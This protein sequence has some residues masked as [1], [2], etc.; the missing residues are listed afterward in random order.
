MP[1]LDYYARLDDLQQALGQLNS[2][3]LK[4]ALK[5]LNLA[6]LQKILRL[7]K[8]EDMHKALSQLNNLVAPHKPLSEWTLEDLQ[9]V[10]QQL[11]PEDLRI[12]LQQLPP[13]D[14]CKALTELNLEY[15]HKARRR[16]DPEDT[17]KAL[18]ELNLEHLL[19]VLKQL[20]LEDLKKAL[21]ELNLEDLKK[22][23]NE[24]NLEDLKKALS[25]MNLEDLEKVFMP[26]ND[27]GLIAGFVDD[28]TVRGCRGN[29]RDIS[30]EFYI[31]EVA[32]KD[33]TEIKH[34]IE[35]DKEIELNLR[36]DFTSLPVDD[37]FGL[38]VNFT[39]QTPLYSKDDR[40]FHILDNPMRKEKVFGLPYISASS[41]KGMLR[42]ACQM[43]EGLRKHLKNNN[44]QME[45]WQ[46][47]PWI[48]HLFGN[49]RGEAKHFRSGALVFY[50]TF[51]NRLSFEV[52]NPHSR[53]RRAGIQP[54]FY[55][56]VPA[57]AQGTLW[58]LYAPAPGA[59]ERDKVNAE[60][61]KDNLK[62]SIEALL[63]KY[64]IG[65]KH[66]AGWGL[67]KIDKYDSYPK[68]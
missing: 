63:E 37:W 30:R 12:I 67:A 31:M 21:S 42:W 29:E 56:V 23:L 65:A 36:P 25:E 7:L 62:N 38:E 20:N 47:P 39:L 3:D 27:W 35:E 41:W 19:K 48:L 5:Q 60:K 33:F 40:P 26:W 45:G 1:I 9:E 53:A 54:I 28:C 52:I 4:N 6:D 15:L 11:A 44:M 24:L 32:D 64:G 68:N 14:L 50:P 17:Q 58:L 43:H 57:G 8:W 61:I 59:A 66:T 46:D 34:L 2:K 18:K 55:E 13:E 16:L 49:P 22:A 10:L 51:F